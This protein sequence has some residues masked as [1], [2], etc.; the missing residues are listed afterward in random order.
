MW[1]KNDGLFHNVHQIKMN[2]EGKDYSATL[3]NS[4]VNARCSSK[5]NLFDGVETVKGFYYL[6]LGL[7]ASGSDTAVTVKLKIG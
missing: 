5:T 4:L 1:Q 2:R 7:Y 3:A 6:V